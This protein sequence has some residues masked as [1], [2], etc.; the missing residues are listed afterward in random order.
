MV[1]PVELL[2]LDEGNDS[3]GQMHSDQLKVK[4]VVDDV[5]EPLDLLVAEVKSLLLEF[6]FGLPKV[7]PTLDTLF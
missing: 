2:P 1:E 4:T 6:V 5:A 3:A 7:V